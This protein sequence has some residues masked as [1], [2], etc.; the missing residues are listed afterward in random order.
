MK[1][2]YISFYNT[3]SKRDEVK[4]M[5]VFLFL[6]SSE[7]V[8]TPEGVAP[9]VLYFC[10]EKLSTWMNIADHVDEACRVLSTHVRKYF[11]Q[12]SRDV[13]AKVVGEY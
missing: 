10:R 9:T 2:M 4:D 1:F 5:A 3:F 6:V 13:V 7:W 12:N 8:L 11:G